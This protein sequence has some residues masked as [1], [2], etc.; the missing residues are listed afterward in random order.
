MTSRQGRR[1]PEHRGAPDGSSD[2]ATDDDTAEVAR[3]HGRPAPIAA[4]EL[5]TDPAS[6]ARGLLGRL[7]V[8]EH[9]DGRVVARVVETEAYGPDDPASH[10]ARGMTPRCAAMFGP[11]GT[12]YVYRSYGVHWCLNVAVGAPGTGA[13]V[14]LRAATV[15]EGLE[16]VQARRPHVRAAR[17]LLRG[18]GRLA[19]GLA[20]DA[21]H[22]GIDLLLPEGELRLT[23]DGWE[24]HAVVAGP[25][26]GVRLAPEVPW[27][28][29]LPGV[30]EVSAYRRSPR[31]G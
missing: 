17:D 21:A 16:V 1:G 5:D 12:A 28:F 9:A 25:R 29:H 15:V 30:R 20:V 3:W 11:P 22:D 24:P 8:R 7:L 23:R 19:S 13:A 6:A 2:G 27:R 26:V 18:P 10:S 4:A 31:A 14:L